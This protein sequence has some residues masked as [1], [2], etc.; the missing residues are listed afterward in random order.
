MP[1]GRNQVGRLNNDSP[2]RYAAS[3]TS[4]LDATE[5][6]EECYYN[7]FGSKVPD[8]VLCEPGTDVRVLGIGSGS[9]EADSII[10]KKLL[11]RH[12]GV[13]NRVVEPSG[14]MIEKYKALVREDTILRAVKF[15]WHQQTTEEYFQKKENAKFHLIHAINVLYY[16][17]DPVA[18]L[19]NMW[20]QLADGGYMLVTMESEKGDW[21]KLHLELWKDF[22][23]GDRL[24]TSLRLSGDVKKWLDAMDATYVSF[25]NRIDVNTTKCFDEKSEEGILLLDFITHT[26][27]TSSVP[28]MRSMALDF[29]RRHSSVVDD[30]IIFLSIEETIVAFKK[31]T[32][33]K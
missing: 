24:D 18:T 19:R 32:E 13:Y 3:F 1:T 17:E 6:S 27:Y 30:K 22:G 9:G 26:P 33:K 2:A 28:E 10:T 8:S 7:F 12:E 11:Q 16:V 29:I 23:Q 5:M 21:G 25:E 15:D 31:G 20:E 4:F 14:E